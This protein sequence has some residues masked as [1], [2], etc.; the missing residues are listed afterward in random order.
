[1]FGAAA[2]G[3]F[4]TIP[5]SSFNYRTVGVNLEITPRVTYEG[6]SRARALASRAARSAQN[7]D[8]AGQGVPSFTSRKVTTQLRLREGE[9]K[10]L[11][12]LIGED[13]QR[14]SLSGFPGLIRRSRLQA[15]ALRATKRA[16]KN[17]D[18]VML[19]TP[20]IVRTHELTSKDLG[21][22]Y[23]G[24]QQNVGLGGPPPLIAPQGEARRRSAALPPAQRL[25]TVP[26]QPPN[27]P[28]GGVA[29]AWWRSADQPAGAARHVAG[30]RHGHAG[31]DA[32]RARAAATAAGRTA[33]PG[34]GAVRRTPSPNYRRRSDDR[35]ASRPV[36][37]AAPSRRHRARRP[38][39][40]AADR[41]G[42]AGDAG[43]DHRV[44]A[45][46]GVPR[47]R[48]ALHG[49]G[50]DQ[51][52]VARLGRHAD[53]DLQ[54]GRAA[55]AHGAGRHVHAAGR[56]DR[57]VHAAHRCRRPAASTSRSRG[58]VI[59]PARRARGCWRR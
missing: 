26:N 37:P 46:D 43:A 19:I 30:A 34:A 21:S 4:A 59:R 42:V 33:A 38:A 40:R 50:V 23:I 8:V 22:I 18:I 55:R 54:P 7:V 13:E 1:M 11:A 20:H 44:A 15:V 36:T 25:D 45:R 27:I 2:A 47:R 49:A 35:R 28:P 3:G 53:G 10:L 32:A 17:T 48:R 58:P 52:R 24:T 39:S 5:Q 31:R 51:Q 14:Q 16:C 57:V 41:R 56:R 9:S 6:E 12:G 29:N